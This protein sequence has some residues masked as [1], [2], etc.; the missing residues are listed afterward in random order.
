MNVA[1]VTGSGKKRVG[2]VVADAL[3]QH[4][5]ALAIHY[6]S[7]AAEAE[8]SATA[9][10]QRGLEV[11]LVQADLRDEAAVKSMIQQVVDRFKRIDVLVNCAAEWK[12]KKLE[13]VT[14]A[15]VRHYFE[16]NTLG[17]FLCC[18]HAGRLMVEQSRTERSDEQLRPTSLDGRNTR[19]QP[20]HD[21]EYFAVFEPRVAAE[22][23]HPGPGEDRVGD[24]QA[25]DLRGHGRARIDE[26]DPGKGKQQHACRP[27][28][29]R[30]RVWPQE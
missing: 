23:E 8:E 14:A 22:C 21:C 26:L 6:R 9:Y 7:S 15:D 17:T 11:L 30:P 13:E 24:N 27:D 12:S 3:A 29:E 5:Y 16:L 19:E 2:S 20:E 4:G 18:Q 10:R 1:L 28:A 25:S